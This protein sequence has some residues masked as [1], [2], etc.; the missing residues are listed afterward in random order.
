MKITSKG[1]VTIPKGIRDKFGLLPGT[2]VEFVV[3]GGQVKVRKKKGGRTRGQEIVEHLR[4]ASGGDVKMSTEEIMRLTR[5]EDWGT[6]RLEEGD[7]DPC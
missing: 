6:G 1:Q 4:R 2:E 3:E 5:G 7:G